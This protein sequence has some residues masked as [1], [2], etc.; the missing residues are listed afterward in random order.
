MEQ[1]LETNAARLLDGVRGIVKGYEEQWQKTGEKYNIFEITDINDDEVKVCRV[2]AGLLNPRGSHA[3]GSLY[4]RLFWETV[5]RKLPGGI[6]LDF[7]KAQ[8]SREY[9]IG[10]ERRI[11]IVLETGNV[12]VPI[13][14][15]IRA[16]DQQNQV[17]DYYGFS[18]TKPGGTRVFYLTLDGHTPA[19]PYSAKSESEYVTISF[20]DDILPW[21]E[22]CLARE[23]TNK[24]PAVWEVLK[25]LIVAIKS[26]CGKLEDNE[27][28]DVFKL[29][30]ESEESIKAAA[31]IS[32]AKNNLD[33]KVLELF[34]GPVQELLARKKFDAKYVSEYESEHWYPIYCEVSKGEYL[35]Y[36]NYDW[37]KAWLYTE[38]KDNVSSKEGKALCEAL[39]RLLGPNKGSSD[40]TVWLTERAAYPDPAFTAARADRLVYLYR[41]YK[42]YMEKP[43]EVADRIVSIVQALESVKV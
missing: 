5:S 10:E 38:N 36:I 3:K 26:L 19:I 25:Q 28:N 2:L 35:L 7:K 32:E 30:T 23:E 37:N 41:L 29:I 11:D 14:V 12:F 33:S 40:D 27:M 42:L 39:I 24:T 16:P 1:T 22:K 34:K 6:S 15:K 18:Q 43:Q 8:V 20:A 21:L 31:A 17:H 9:H 4:L 13:E